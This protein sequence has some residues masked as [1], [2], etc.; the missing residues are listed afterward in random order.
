MKEY[1]YR[2]LDD[3]NKAVLDIVAG[4]SYGECPYADIAEKL[5]KISRNNKV[6]STR[7]SDTER[8]T[9]AVQFH[10]QPCHRWDSWRN[11]SDENWASVGIKIGVQKK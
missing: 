11:G 5:K 6:W 4:E 7:K 8:N 1:F 2:G 10:S 3:D 9:F